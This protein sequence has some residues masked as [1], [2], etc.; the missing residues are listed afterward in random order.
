MHTEQQHV[1]TNLKATFA[2]ISILFSFYDEDQQQSRD[3][4]GDQIKVGFHYVGAECKDIVLL[5]QVNLLGHLLSYTLECSVDD[6]TC[7]GLT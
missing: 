5:M 4:K 7:P 2:G 3:P 1:Q 6:S